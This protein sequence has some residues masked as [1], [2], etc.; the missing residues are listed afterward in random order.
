ME[1]KQKYFG[2]YRMPS[3]MIEKEF[4]KGHMNVYLMG[5]H[6]S[7][8]KETVRVLKRVGDLNGKAWMGIWNAV[9]KYDPAVTLRDGWQSALRYMMTCLAEEGVLDTVLG[10]YFDEPFLCGMKKSL[11]RIRLST[12]RMKNS[13]KS[14]KNYIKQ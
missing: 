2:Y 3:D 10:F 5:V 4:L 11:F 1:L 9:V 13:T 12:L 6:P 8:M 7:D 14:M